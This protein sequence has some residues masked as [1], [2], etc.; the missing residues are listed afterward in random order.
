VGKGP[1]ASLP[2]DLVQIDHTLADVIVVDETERRPVGRPWLTL[3]IDVAT[4]SV[5]GFYLSLDSPSSTSVALAI[6]HAVLPKSD[7]LRLVGVDR[8]WPV[9]GI[10]QTFHLDN[11][12]EFH[13][14]ALERGCR[15]HGI[16]LRYRPPR[17]PH[18]G[19]HIERLIGTFM[20]KYT[21]FRGR[22]F[23]PSQIGEIMIRPVRRS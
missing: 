22:R 3:A 5:A 9:H 2:L 13:G 11:A 17:T 1:V 10:P 16:E 8:S 14:Q 12:K 18:Y 20:G 21:L 6:A 7:Y 19:G 4:R 15:E 23:H